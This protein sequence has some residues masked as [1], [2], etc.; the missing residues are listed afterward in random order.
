MTQAEMLASL[1]EIAALTHRMFDALDKPSAKL[2]ALRDVNE[3]QFRYLLGGIV[4]NTDDAI[5]EITHRP[6]VREWEKDAL[7]VPNPS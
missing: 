5:E 1:R 6:S 7:T 3:Q 2:H 4:V